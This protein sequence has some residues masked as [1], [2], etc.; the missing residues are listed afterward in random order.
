MFQEKKMSNSQVL[1]TLFELALHR[2]KENF[3]HYCHSNK[4]VPS[5]RDL[6][7]LFPLLLYKM[8]V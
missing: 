7:K 5:F 1:C 3:E 8:V 2:V 4:R 6:R